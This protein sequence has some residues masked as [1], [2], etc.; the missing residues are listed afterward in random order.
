M[1]ISTRIPSWLLGSLLV[2]VLGACGG[3]SK[4]VDDASVSDAASSSDASSDAAS[5]ADSSSAGAKDGGMDASL[6]H[7]AAVIDG[8]VDASIDAAVDAAVDAAIGSDAG[9]DASTDASVAMDAA[10]DAAVDASVPDAAVDAGTDAGA[11]LTGYR[12]EIWGYNIPTQR[13]RLVWST[14][15]NGWSATPNW[16]NHDLNAPTG[17]YAAPDVAFIT[18]P[19]GTTCKDAPHDVDLYTNTASGAPFITLSAASGA[20]SW[21]STQWYVVDNDTYYAGEDTTGQG[22]EGLPTDFTQCTWD[23]PPRDGTLSTVTCPH[24]VVNGWDM[25]SGD[26]TFQVRI[27]PVY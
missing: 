22:V 6:A 15:I 23:T 16:Q 12:I 14:A 10:V 17:T 3:G 2:V 24:Q 13:R 5:A 27:W 7:D 19:C 4:A 18:G 25:L 21:I 1:K 9:V 20:P 26:I 11:V 8:A